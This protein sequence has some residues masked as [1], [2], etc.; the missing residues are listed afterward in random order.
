MNKYLDDYY[1]VSGELAKKY[2][3]N[4][5]GDNIPKLVI[6]SKLKNILDWSDFE[7]IKLN[8]NE[9]ERLIN[10]IYYY[11]VSLEDDIGEF[12]A[13]RAVMYVLLK[14]YNGNFADFI[15]D[16]ENNYFKV[17]DLFLLEL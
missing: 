12:V 4:A 7:N 14:N 10:I 16:C 17:R 5:V 13:T 11:I 15:N 9:Q 3:T 2:E 6:A 8:D 1:R